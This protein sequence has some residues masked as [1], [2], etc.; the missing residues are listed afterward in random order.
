MARKGQT[1]RET[2]KEAVPD[3]PKES[4]EYCRNLFLRNNLTTLISKNYSFMDSRKCAV[5]IGILEEI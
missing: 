4:G 5:L 2:K 3:L 1:G